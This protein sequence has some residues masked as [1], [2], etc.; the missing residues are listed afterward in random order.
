VTIAWL[1]AL[2]WPLWDV[3]ESALV[4]ATVFVA[5]AAAG[6]ARAKG[7]SDRAI[8][9]HGFAA[10][11]IVAAAIGADALGSL[12]GGSQ[13][14]ADVTVLGYSGAVTL[15]AVVLFRAALLD[16]PTSL[17]ERAVALERGGATLRDALRD[18]LGD[19][20]L[21]VGFAA[22]AGT[23]VDDRDR[24]LAPPAAGLVATPVTVAGQAVGLVVH[25]PETLDNEA[26][27]SAVLAA[28]GLASQRARL[29]AEVDR[30][31]DEIEASRR[32]LLLAE[33]E[34]RRRL[35]GRLDRGP[36]AALVDVERLVREAS[37]GGNDALAAPLE[38]ASDQLAQVRPELD[39]LVRGLGG[40]DPDGLVAALERLAVGL[41]LE[42]ELELELADVTVSPELASA[43]WF[44]CSESLANVVKH[45]VAHRVRVTLAAGAGVVLL[46]VEDDGRGG[47]N[48]QGPGLVGLADRVAALGGRLEIGS[49]PAGGTRVAAELPLGD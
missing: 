44:V 14:V 31:V 42:V 25:G 24:P 9:A 29:R 19:P 5:I 40:L 12:A 18:L 39:S 46:G 30:Q 22:G 37:S 36:G 28:V 23:F 27:R 41:P 48:P 2:A 35:A 43:L 38:R 47:A 7:R 21:D 20:A 11:G 13:T 26:T 15:A 49:S 16:A 8:A 34:E 33:E 4:L 1:A 17:A 3:D 10:V 45:A 6:Y 32:R